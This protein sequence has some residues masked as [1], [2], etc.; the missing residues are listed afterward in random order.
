MDEFDTVYPLA[1]A[2]EL[3]R[4]LLPKKSFSENIVELDHKRGQQVY[5]RGQ[6]DKELEI[7]AEEHSKKTKELSSK[8]SAL[9]ESIDTYDSCIRSYVEKNINE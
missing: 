5:Q 4:D 3:I 6:I 7:M 9:L 2:S 1:D 8:K